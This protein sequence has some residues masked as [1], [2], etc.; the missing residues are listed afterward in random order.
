MAKLGP[1][2]TNNMIKEAKG[3]LQLCRSK[4]DIHKSKGN[5]SD[6]VCPDWLGYLAKE[7][8]AEKI[9]IYNKNE[10]D[11][12]N[13]GS[14]LAQYCALEAAIIMLYKVRDEWTMDCDYEQPKGPAGWM[15][16]AHRIWASEFFDTPASG[17]L[18]ARSKKTEDDPW[19]N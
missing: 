11:V 8:W 6:L 10:I 17:Y 4:E 15:I 3:T 9:E 7:I 12:S 14:A 16:S 19:E 18:K 2:G 1:K 13:H 5:N